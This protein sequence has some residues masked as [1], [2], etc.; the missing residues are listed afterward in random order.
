[1]NLKKFFGGHTVALETP[2][3]TPIYSREEILI[4]ELH[5]IDQSREEIGEAI[6]DFRKQNTLLRD[7]RLCY[8]TDAID[9]RA[10]LDYVWNGLLNADSKLLHARNLVLRDLAAI[11]CPSYVS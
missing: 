1:M 8:Q 11:R 5:H 3:P 7:G 6:R 9:K 10:E 4:A 2:T